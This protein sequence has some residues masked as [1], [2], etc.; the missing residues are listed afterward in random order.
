ASTGTERLVVLAETRATDPAAR[1][2]LRARA[3]DVAASILGEPADEIVL[4][5]PRIIPK[6][7]SGKVRRSS[8]KELYERGQLEARPTAMWWQLARLGL[9][10]IGPQI[11][12]LGRVV[13]QLVY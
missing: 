5:A 1:E 3:K 9:A 4:V 7:S 10:G 11:A 2:A 6:T 12:R 13:G 8:A